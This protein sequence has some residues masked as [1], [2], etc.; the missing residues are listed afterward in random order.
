[1]YISTTLPPRRNFKLKN[2]NPILFLLNV[3][4]PESSIP[5]VNFWFRSI[6][7]ILFECHSKNSLDCRIHTWIITKINFSSYHIHV[8]RTFRF[9]TYCF[10]SESDLIVILFFVSTYKHCWKSLWV[11]TLKIVWIERIHVLMVTQN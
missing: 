1:M 4:L 10:L 8:K 7:G 2:S 11:W 5:F 3:F 9:C 6:D